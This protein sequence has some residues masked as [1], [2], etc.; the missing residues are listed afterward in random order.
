M[1]T[2]IDCIALRTTRL[3]D[4]KSLLSAWTRQHGR[5]TFSIPAG[6]SK[7]ARRRRAL[8]AP[9]HTFEGVSDIR[10]DH[11]IHFIRDI[12][13]SGTPLALDPDP[14][15]SM[16]A[17]FLA[18]TLDIL[19]R[20]ADADPNLSDFLFGSVDALGALTDPRATANFHLVFLYR[21]TH[22]LGIEP[23]LD[24]QGTVFDMRD[25]RFRATLPF[26]SDYIRDR[27]C[28]LLHALMR[29]NYRSAGRLPLDR[30]S[31]KVALDKILHYYSI[32][33]TS[34]SGLKSLD[35]LRSLLE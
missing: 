17:I 24:H 33:L 34:L 23:Q 8:T 29:A 30:Y 1:Y 26:H 13:S 14:A 9:L 7:E 2:S 5:L 35:I 11:D 4:T 15:K 19:L 12:R 31:R 27:E 25:A 18:D 10:P 28:T 20:R 32:H 21:L 3:S 16:L 6:A 22:F